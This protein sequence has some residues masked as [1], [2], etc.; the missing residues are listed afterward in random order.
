MSRV[1]VLFQANSTECGVAC[2]AMVLSYHGHRMSVRQAREVCALGRDGVSAGSLARTARGLGLN[3][4]GRKPAAVEPGAIRLPAIAHWE[5]NHFVVVERIGRRRVHVVDPRFGRRRLTRAEFDAGLG[6]AVLE[7]WPTARFT[8][9]PVDTEP[10]WRGYAR[11]LLRLRGTRALLGQIVLASL[12][13]QALGL[14]V[15]LLVGLVAEDVHGLRQPSA[16]ALIGAGTILAVAAQLVTAYLRSTVVIHLQGRLDVHALVGFCAHLLRLPLRYFQQRSTGDVMMRIGSIAVLR[17]LLT[18]QTLSSILDAGM[19]ATYV[20]I[21][22]VMDVPSGLLVLGVI[23]LQ[24]AVLAGSVRWI[25]ERMAAD[26]AAQA[27]AQ[28]HVVETLTGIATLKASAAEERTLSQWTELFLVWMRTTLRRSHA[29]A[30]VDGLA[31]ALRMLTPLAVLWIGTTRVLAGDLSLGTM[32]AATWLSAAVAAPLSVLVSNG[33]RLQL[34]GAQL[35]RLADVLETEPEFSSAPAVERPSVRG[36]VEF[37]DV[38]FRYEEESPLALEGVSFRI[39]PGQRVA[40]VGRTGAGKSTLGMLLLGLYPPSE[41][42]ILIDGFSLP[43][44]DPR[45]VRAASGVVLQEPLVFAG[46]IADNITLR[47]PLIS[48]EEVERAARLAELHDE[49][50]AFPMKYDSRL[51]ER[52][53]G[54]SGGQ[55]QRLAIARA[56]VRRPVL[57]L[58]DEAT[59]HLDSVTE[60]RIHQNLRA[61]GCTQVIVAHRLSTIRDADLI[62]VLEKGRLVEHGR[63]H[64]LLAGRGRYA[65]LVAAQVG[66][67]THPNELAERR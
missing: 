30:V 15:P 4:V 46:T 48:R 55:K 22:L 34:A 35:Q 19:V 59:S 54:L 17:E 64:G 5:G 6:K 41:G 42:A 18:T 8:P 53:G 56:L 13:L 1:P 58:L 37:R 47:D 33:Q 57:L 2:L 38:G 16:L 52:G 65:D 24:A 49:I 62:L 3:V 28:S 11:S 9:K 10:F 66:T 36:E 43:D 44:R 7:L 12:V 67:P 60:A 51:S 50:T 21:L 26:L 39:E 61:V 31:G 29:A 23:G 27:E 63:H 40:V 32:L 14:A 20:A 25:R 45:Q